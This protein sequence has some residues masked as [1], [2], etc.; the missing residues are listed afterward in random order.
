MNT[1]H[2]ILYILN[3]DTPL[4]P[5]VS[6]ADDNFLYMLDFADEPSL[7]KELARLHKRLNVSI[8]PGETSITQGIKK[9][10]EGYFSGQLRHFETPLYLVGTEFQQS[11]WRALQL[12]PYGETR[13]YL[14]MAKSIDKPTGF[15]AVA[16]AN[17]AN[18]LA[19]VIPCHRVINH[20]GELGGYGGGLP[21]KQWLLAH[22]KNYFST[23]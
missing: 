5:M 9:E 20:N 7:D 8:V 3:I 18:L 2:K 12:I 22:E 23:R 15:R 21:R 11:V 16:L 17:G 1:D 10:L 4:G 6:V 13:S 14:D 19:V